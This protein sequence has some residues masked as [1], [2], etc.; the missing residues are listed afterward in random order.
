MKYTHYI[1]FPPVKI[2]VTLGVDD[3]GQLVVLNYNA[4]YRGIANQAYLPMKPSAMEP[5]LQ[6]WAIKNQD[7]LIKR[8]L[9][10]ADRWQHIHNRSK[11]ELIC[12]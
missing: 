8:H 6:D 5:W 1:Q 11:L 7:M 2:R 3:M 12:G 10:R 4:V 9:A